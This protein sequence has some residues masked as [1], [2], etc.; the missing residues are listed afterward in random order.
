MTLFKR[1]AVVAVL[2]GAGLLLAVPPVLALCG[3]TDPA[4]TVYPIQ[5]NFVMALVEAMVTL[6]VVLAL[7]ARLVAMFRLV[8]LNVGA[9]AILGDPTTGAPGLLRGLLP[10]IM[11][12]TLFAVLL[13]GVFMIASF[14]TSYRV[15]SFGRIFGVVL[16]SAWFLASGPV[17]ITGY[18]QLRSGLGLLTYRVASS[19]I[20]ASA[21]SAGLPLGSSSGD[22]L[23]I[24]DCNTMST[25]GMSAD[26][27][28]GVCN[29]YGATL[30]WLMYRSYDTALTARPSPEFQAKYFTVTGVNYYPPEGRSELPTLACATP[31]FPTPGTLSPPDELLAKS[32]DGLGRAV[33]ALPLAITGLLEQIIWFVLTLGTLALFLSLA[34]SLVFAALS[35]FGN[36]LSETVN[37]LVKL[38]TTT[39]TA[40]F[41]LGLMS[42]LLFYVAE[43]GNVIYFSGASLLALAIYA[44]LLVQ[45]LSA[46]GQALM[47]AGGNMAQSGGQ[48][49]ARVAGGVPRAVRGAVS[50]LNRTPV[51]SAVRAAGQYG[52]GVAEGAARELGLP[53]NVNFRMRGQHVGGAAVE[54]LGGGARTTEEKKEVAERNKRNADANRAYIPTWQ[55]AE[56]K[57]KT[58]ARDARLQG[59]AGAAGGNGASGGTRA[60]TPVLTNA[61][62]PP[63]GEEHRSGAGR[64]SGAERR[65][66]IDR[67][68]VPRADDDR[69]S[70][71]D[72]RSGYDR[73]DLRLPLPPLLPD[74]PDMT[75]SPTGLRPPASLRQRLAEADNSAANAD[76][77]N[78][79][80]GANAPTN[81]DGA[82]PVLPGTPMTTADGPVISVVEPLPPPPPLADVQQDMGAPRPANP[83][84]ASARASLEAAQSGSDPARAWETDSGVKLSGMTGQVRGLA[85]RAAEAGMTGDTFAAVLSEASQPGG[86]P[87]ALALAETYFLDGSSA[88]TFVQQARRVARWAA[89][90]PKKD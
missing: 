83:W 17:L 56:A 76:G 57:E 20:S 49:L 86:E 84:L 40:G 78:A 32:L 11:L 2:V 33:M 62:P 15:S 31:L 63:L 13:L 47:A 51:G 64:R 75:D 81:A 23:N 68:D 18:D 45:A 55:R 3:P 25:T 5:A 73:R 58:D 59:A 65:D 27:L 53:T 41:Y 88:G 74:Q 38:L 52:T 8:I 60:P 29:G 43:H 6:N 67:R 14:A 39:V 79:G 1:R 28:D 54:V 7:C 87:R 77:A 30:T 72:Q 26:P 21:G 48:A 85:Q 37:Q 89:P 34:L 80:L 70:G 44:A 36:Q 9:T 90:L 69:R 12:M 22:S 50:G 10:L 24:G 71:D 61:P 46:T 42:G 66:G 19:A 4:A 35:P 16:L 82:P